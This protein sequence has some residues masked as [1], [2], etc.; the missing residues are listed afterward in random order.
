MPPVQFLE[1]LKQSGDSYTMPG[2]YHDRIRDSDIKPLISR[3]DAQTPCGFVGSAVS[4][5]LPHARST[6]AR[7]AADL[8]E[9]YRRHYY[10]PQLSSGDFVPDS[11]ELCQWFQVWSTRNK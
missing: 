1:E 8:I 5:K 3:L 4:S 11:A 2:S 7:P 9:G 10:P 6:E